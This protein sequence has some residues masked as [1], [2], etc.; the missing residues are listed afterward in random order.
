MVNEIVNRLII[1][2]EE[3]VTSLMVDSFWSLKVVFYRS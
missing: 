1:L 2:T 3:K